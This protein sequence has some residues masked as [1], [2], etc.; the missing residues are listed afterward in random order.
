MV[1]YS[2]F[3]LLSV[4]TVLGFALRIFHIDF[5]S[6]WIDELL[7]ILKA[8]QKSL[9]E[10]IEASKVDVHP[11]LYD[12]LIHFWIYFGKTAATL[13]FFSLI[14]GVGSIPVIYLVGK[15]IYDEKVGLTAAFILTIWPFSIWYSQEVRPYTLIF[16][17]GLLSIGFFLEGIET[18]S[19]K[20]WTNFIILTTLCL[21]TNH[22]TL[23]LIFVF[24]IFIII[25]WLNKK[26]LDIFNR[27]IIV[28]III[29]FL[30]IPGLYILVSQ[31]LWQKNSKTPEMLFIR[32]PGFTTIPYLFYNLTFYADALPLRWLRGIMLIPI[33][34]VFF[35]GLK[36][37]K[38][39]FK[40]IKSFIFEGKN[41]F[42]I[43][44]LFLPITIS[45][46]LGVFAKKEF[47]YDARY[48][49][50]FMPAYLILL[51]RGILQINH[52]SAQKFLITFCLI[53]V[54]A[55]NYR[56]YTIPINPPVK[57]VVKYIKDR[58]L[59]GDI[60]FMH[61]STWKIVFDYYSNNRIVTEGVL[62]NYDPKYGVF[63]YEFTQVTE[64]Y[65]PI[66]QEKLKGYSRL[67]IVLTPHEVRRDPKEIV[68]R[69]L[70][71][72]FENKLKK[73]IYPEYFEILMYDLR[74]KK[75]V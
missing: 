49:M 34:I 9:L 12:Y 38:N 58:Y 15:K 44:C 22:A 35:S 73:K 19:W 45:F 4:F 74:A 56:I 17:L 67:W 69:Y 40:G 6:L 33:I 28:Q 18:N 32:Q 21:Y 26:H 59:P 7:V 11:P 66:L 57:E 20:Y 50:I 46:I 63:P 54:F 61:R 27:W 68:V 64:N 55:A 52:K 1:R 3:I 53:S 42:L 30:Y 2:S 51:S 13:R 70:D 48:F 29:I 36:P 65:I 43:L 47:M 23:Y 41:L 5:Q 37:F 71:N 39:T 14:F 72:H 75:K 62:N 16:F 25:S 31:L 8:E 24:N 10:I 60:V